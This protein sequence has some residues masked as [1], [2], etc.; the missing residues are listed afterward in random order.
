M[1]T[2]STQEGIIDLTLSMCWKEI[3]HEQCVWF[4]RNAK[5]KSSIE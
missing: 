5:G 4:V 1:R 2:V 3:I